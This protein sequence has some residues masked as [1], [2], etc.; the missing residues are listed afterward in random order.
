MKLIQRHRGWMSWLVVLLA[1]V[2]GG[3][4]IAQEPEEK[5]TE[6]KQEKKKAGLPL[7]PERT[8][9]FTTDE[10]T[11][12]SLDVSP[13]GKT[14]LFELLGDLYTLPIAGGETTRITSGVAFDSQ[15]RYSPDGKLIAFLSDRDGAENLWIAKADGSEPKQL[16]KEKSL[17]LLASP[18]WTPDGTYVIVSRALGLLTNEL[19]MYHIRGG[20]GVRITK[21][22]AKPDTPR[23]RQHNAL[24]TV[25]SPDGRYLY[26]ARKL[27]GFA[28]NILRFPLWQIARRDRITGDEDIITQARG[29]AFRPLLSPDGTKL[30]YG[31]RYETKTGLRLR[32]LGTGEE[33]WLR[34]P[35]Q[36]DDQESRFTRDLLPG[37]AFTPDG[38]E[39]V[40][41]YGGKIHRVDV[42]TGAARM[43]PFTAKVSQEVGPLLNFPVRV[44]EGPVRARLIQAPVQSPDGKRLAFSAL[45][46]L[47]VMDIPDGMPRRFTADT[48]REF[49]PAWSPGGN[50]LAYVTWSEKGGHIWKLRADGSG[51]PEQLTRVPAFYSDLAWS[52]DGS[53]IVALRAPRQARVE[54]PVDFGSVPD[55]DLIW[56][57]AQGGEA[58]LIVPARGAGRPHFTHE[59]DRVYVY[60]SKG[61]LSLRY[62]G[63]DRRTHIKIVA[64]SRFVQPQPPP[65]QDARLSPDGRWALARVHNQLYLVAVPQ[66]GGQA[67]TVDVSSPS[68]PVKKLTDVGADYF[69]WADGGQTITW[70][71]GSTFF[72][73]PVATVSFEPEKKEE[74][75]EEA[76]EANPSTSLGAGQAEEAKEEKESPVEEIEVVIE[77][78]RHRPR[79]TIVLRGAKVITLRGDEVIRNA[80]IVV[81]DNRLVGVGRRGRM[82]I[83][84]GAR[85]FD[86]RG[87]TIIPGFVDTH[88]H[89][90]EIRRGVL[91]MQNWSFLAN[92]AYGVTTGRDP[93]TGTNDMF[94]Y[95]DLVDVGEMIGL[96]AFSTGPGVFWS[97]DFQSLEEAKNVVAKYKKYY[98]THTLKSYMV[99][100]RKQRQWM[101]MAAKEHGIMP[102]TEGALDLKLDLTHVIDGF[103]GN[104]HAFPIVPLYK[105]VAELVAR[106]GLFYT[107][108]LLVAYGGPWAENYFYQTTEVHDDTKV[109]R[110]IPHNIL[111]GRTKRRPWF[112]QEEHVYPKLAAAAAKIIRAGG[113][114]CIGSHGQLQ[115]IGYHW[116]LWAL[117][118][119]G[120]TPMEALRAA[121][122]HGAEAIGYAQDLGSIEVGK[123]ADLIVLAKDPLQD[124]RNTNT[125]RYVMK[126]GELF[127]GDTLNQVWPEQK[128]LPELWWWDDKP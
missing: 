124:I 46:H 51:E 31:T 12:L 9:A 116:E 22:K 19:W 24:G 41:S 102:T 82:G 69:A 53:R 103:S 97:T 64:K 112:R 34:Y 55:L 47:Y 13:D 48:A 16:S 67:P 118:S 85:I 44:D 119:G 127:E 105:D 70:A 76:E 96:R 94:A 10:G 58:K 17:S 74:K 73:Q 128:P 61:L 93:Q 63:T 32:E 30:V 11:W 6:A 42:E 80:D 15:P 1:L 92:L 49:Q 37:Y 33:H 25:V 111:D 122:L 20:S 104:E 110:F 50:W 126:N 29:S 71:L 65:A 100:N 45:T 84:K 14:I 88:A 62:D 75:E 26:Y 83:P 120:L 68:V 23:N 78:P 81:T 117:A 35:V 2:V 60:S 86:V 109:R 91:D 40:V 43:I 108:T 8:I 115:G 38:K 101:V 107:P 39:I 21:A 18:T 4:G 95:Q 123:L 99:G 87:S 121:T 77:R 5:K 7:K 113:R 66:V 90:F 57:P 56:I 28:Y 52:P 27:G 125:I 79:G 54:R 36:R 98:R 72:R 106:A 89:W 114:V 59:K 3:A